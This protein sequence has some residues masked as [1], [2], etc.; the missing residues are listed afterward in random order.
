MSQRARAF[1]RALR[2]RRHE[3]LA[4]SHARNGSHAVL[5]PP[6]S[7]RKLRL[8]DPLRRIGWRRPSRREED[9]ARGSGQCGLG[10]TE[11]WEG[12]PPRLREMVGA[13]RWMFIQNHWRD[14]AMVRLLRE[15]SGSVGMTRARRPFATL[16]LGVTM[17]RG[18]CYF[19]AAWTCMSCQTMGRRVKSLLCNPARR[20][21]C[22]RAAR[23]RGSHFSRF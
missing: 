5:D 14:E 16:Y 6:P 23:E 13:R 9:R 15:R 20:T 1:R 8:G 21:R 10:L 11:R 3:R 2:C 12:R 22:R 18:E 7:C 17:G 19:S 4:A